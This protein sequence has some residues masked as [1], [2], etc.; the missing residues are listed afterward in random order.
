MK[1]KYR[2]IRSSKLTSKPI[3]PCC[4]GIWVWY[5]DV[6]CK[7]YIKDNSHYKCYRRYCYTC[8]IPLTSPE[9]L[10]IHALEYHPKNFCTECNQVIPNIVPHNV[11]FHSVKE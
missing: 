5:C 1:T 4:L 6:C 8:M 10:A 2:S 11:L 3:K 7:S 9:E